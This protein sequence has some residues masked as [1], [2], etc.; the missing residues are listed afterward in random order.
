MRVSL[1]H[2]FVRVYII[3]ILFLDAKQLDWEESRNRWLKG[4]NK[5]VGVKKKH[6]FGNK[7]KSNVNSKRANV[8]KRGN[9]NKKIKE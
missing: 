9:K 1:K 3:N 8:N 7:F 5:A 4:Y 2:T 6:Q